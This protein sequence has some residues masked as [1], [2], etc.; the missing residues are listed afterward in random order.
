[1]QFPSFDLERYL[2]RYEFKAPY[3]LCCSDCESL[4][5][6][7]LLAR[8][9][10]S[11]KRFLDLGL[12]YTESPG[13][14]ELRALA[15][16]L[17]GE[18]DA[19]RA[20][21]FAGAEEGIYSFMHVLL[22]PGDE[23][24]V[25][26]PCYQSLFQIAENIGCR[27]RKWPVSFAGEWRAD[28]DQ[29]REL[30][31]SKT[32]LV[33]INNPHNPTGA[34]MDSSQMREVVFICEKHGAYLFSDE[35]YRGLEHEVA[36]LPAAA[37]VYDR[38]VSLGV[39]SKTYGLA[40]LRIGWAVSRDKHLLGRMQAFKDYTSICNSAPS[41]FL[42]KVALKNAGAIAE[43]NLEI[44]RSNLALLKDF[45]A[46]HEDLFEWLPPSAGPIAFPR[47][48]SGDSDSFCRDLVQETGV[49]LLPG[50]V[51]GREYA[52]HFRI[53]F[54]RANM[55]ECLEVLERYRRM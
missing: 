24:V 53:G 36:P 15:A 9:P 7:N 41:E 28:I 18:R 47:L 4:S 6:G 12:G 35:V 37:A 40:G 45:F 39:M 2:D 13:D 29:L 20:L 8:E 25:Q 30:T 14:P 55:P 46:R 32:R 10:G 19:D 42:A 21:L 48:V 27:V 5:V 43:R 34:L 23:V 26:W 44:I 49:L 11:E 1:M 50:S 33:V 38:G 3:L 51:Y 16:D 31:N 22:E 17:H 54:G 52:A